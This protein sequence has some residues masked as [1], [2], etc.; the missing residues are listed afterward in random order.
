MTG[1]KTGKLSTTKRRTP[2]AR[3]PPFVC[4]PAGTRPNRAAVSVG[5][6]ETG[7]PATAATHRRSTP[8]PPGPGEDAHRGEAP[9]HL[10]RAALGAS[11]QVPFRILGHGHPDFEGKVAVLAAIIV[12]RH[13]ARALTVV[14][15]GLMEPSL[16]QNIEK[17]LSCVQQPPSPI[18]P[19]GA[20][21]ARAPPRRTGGA[22][23]APKEKE[24]DRK[25]DTIS[26]HR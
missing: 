2:I 26:C 21:R 17:T 3:G 19:P 13:G 18:S 20:A 15:V 6:G 22:G 1:K 8:T 24:G 10:S 7:V 11:G 14:V 25:N 4:D 12:S 9:L 16:I 5:S 23:P